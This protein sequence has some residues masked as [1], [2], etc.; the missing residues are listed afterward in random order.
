MPVGLQRGFQL[1]YNIWHWVHVQKELEKNAIVGIAV[2]I[3]LAC[4]ILII[5]TMN[6]IVGLLAT[7]SICATTCCVIG[8]IPTAGWK[9]G[10]SQLLKLDHKNEFQDKC[11]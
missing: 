4:P 5:A 1:T 11:S 10:V 7:L 6:V 9:L 8:V 2:G 3:S